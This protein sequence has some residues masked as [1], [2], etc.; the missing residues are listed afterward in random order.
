ME[1][2]KVANEEHVRIFNKGTEEWNQWRTAMR[3]ASVPW[4]P[5]LRGLD[6]HDRDL[7]GYDLRSIRLYNSD[8]AKANLSGMNLSGVHLSGADLTGANLGGVEF[9]L[10][11]LGRA[12]FIKANL[13]GT[14]FR[15]ADLWETDFTKS[16]LGGATFAAVDLSTAVGLDDVNANMVTIGIDT[17]YRSQGRISRPFL[18]SAGVPNDFITEMKTLFPSEYLTCFISYNTHDIGFAQRLRDDLEQHRVHTWL[19]EEDSRDGEVMWDDITRSLQQRDRVIVI[20]SEYS[21]KS[22]AVLRE[23]GLTLDREQQEQE[24][25]LLP[26]TLDDYLRHW[27]QHEYRVAVIAKKATDFRGWQKS[28]K[29]TIAFQKVLRALRP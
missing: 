16:D 1:T 3:R 17:L 12:K 28:E 19:W 10:S 2:Q 6:L 11:V 29:Y 27:W 22:E 15:Q 23:I 13:T 26:I 25:I 14:F 21:L 20:C 8:L 24:T 9:Y 18:R 4:A 7:R 5:D